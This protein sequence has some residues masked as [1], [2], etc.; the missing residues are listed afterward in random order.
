M[1][2]GEHGRNKIERESEGEKKE[3]DRGFHLTRKSMTGVHFSPL[4]VQYIQDHA[5]SAMGHENIPLVDMTT[6][7]WGEVSSREFGKRRK[8][9]RVIDML[10]MNSPPFSTMQATIIVD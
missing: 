3:N 9:G 10:H 4:W 5:L 1:G 8:A 7:F 6:A 2:T